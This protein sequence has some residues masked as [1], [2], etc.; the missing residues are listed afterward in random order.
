MPKIGLYIPPD[1]M[2][3]IERFRKRVSFSQLFLA[4]FDAEIVRQAAV[5]DVGDEELAGCVGRLRLEVDRSFEAGRTR[6]RQVGFQWAKDDCKLGH[7]REVVEWTRPSPDEVLRLLTEDY[8]MKT[9]E[10]VPD[11]QQSSLG[12]DEQFAMEGF[13]MGF[14]EGAKQLWGHIKARVLSPTD[15]APLS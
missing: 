3:D 9:N 5:S 14:V 4:A 12:L 2:E 1:R 6:G 11:L 8:G 13:A 15:D 7:L 10:L